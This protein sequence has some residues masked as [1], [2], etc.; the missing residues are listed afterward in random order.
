M[1]VGGCGWTR[2]DTDVRGWTQMYADGCGWARMDMDD[3]AG[4]YQVEC[5]GK[6]D[7]LDGWGE[8][9]AWLSPMT[10]EKVVVIDVQWWRRLIVDVR[11]V[12]SPTLSLPF[13]ETYTYLPYLCT[14]YP[15]ISTDSFL[16]V[17]GRFSPQYFAPDTEVRHLVT[18]LLYLGTN[19]LLSCL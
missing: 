13:I 12:E 2:M 6:K 19:L 18:S 1:D 15:Y 4:E 14:E 5:K 7:S 8:T 3:G 10:L 17:R 9:S 16:S 11:T